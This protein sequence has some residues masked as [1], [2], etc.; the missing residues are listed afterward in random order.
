MPQSVSRYKQLLYKIDDR[1]PNTDEMKVS[2]KKYTLETQITKLIVYSNCKMKLN[3]ILWTMLPGA[4]ISK[5]IETW[6]IQ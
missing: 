5:H 3:V 6:K 2:G 1:F 4:A